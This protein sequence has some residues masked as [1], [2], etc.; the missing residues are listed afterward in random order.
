MNSTIKK[1]SLHPKAK[2]SFYVILA[3][4]A[5]ENGCEKKAYKLICDNKALFKGISYTLHEVK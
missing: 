4:E 1:L 3:M 2:H 5:H